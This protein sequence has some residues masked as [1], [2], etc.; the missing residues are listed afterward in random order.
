[1]CQYAATGRTRSTCHPFVTTLEQVCLSGVMA[2]VA[3][4][5]SP[6]Y[7]RICDMQPHDTLSVR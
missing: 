5:G 4:Q 1:M 7:V 6:A 2:G 3:S